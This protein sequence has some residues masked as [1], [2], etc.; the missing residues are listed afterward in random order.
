MTWLLLILSLPTENTT[1]R[2]RAWRALKASGAA[3]LRDGVYLLP[4]Q[5]NATATLTGIVDD[6]RENG[7]TAYL[8]PTTPENN[9]DFPAFFDRSAEFGELMQEITQSRSRLSPDNAPDTLKLARKMRKAFA[10]LV[11]IDFFPGEARK[12]DEAALQELEVAVGRAMSPD[13]PLAD[14]REIPLLSPNDHNG[15]VWATR[16]RPWVDRLASAWLIRRFIDC[17]ARI[18]WLASPADCP[19]DALGF[20]FDGATFSHVGSRV[21]FETLLA[22][23]DLE[24]PALHRLGGIVH[25]LD[26]GGVQPPEAEGIERVLTGLREGITDDDQLLAAASPLFDGLLTAFEKKTHLG[27]V[28]P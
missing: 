3:V 8:L 13:E 12:Q 6:V 17:D 20:D 4:D 25:F 5:G 27:K 1:A 28:A 10:Q 21:T 16:A 22:S 19:P 11:A 15:R 23:F 2:M 14:V 18:L 26:V 9:T 7:G 24:T